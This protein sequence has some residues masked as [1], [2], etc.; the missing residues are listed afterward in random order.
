MKPKFSSSKS[1]PPEKEEYPQGEVVGDNHNSPGIKKIKQTESINNRPY[2]KTFRKKLRNNST[3]AEAKLWTLLQKSQLEGRKFRRQHSVG[4]YI[5]DFYCPS[6]KLAIEL[7]GE[8][9][10]NE[11]AQLR[12][13]ERTL[14]LNN[15]GINVIRFENKL[16]FENT[17]WVLGEVKRGF[18]HPETPP[19]KGGEP[20]V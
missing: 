14:F 8:V 6:E 4:N 7:D 5:V 20:L 1:S 11:Q 18:N 9:H 2:L 19:S 16:V 3:P 17:E 13:T 10:Y 12:D 15:Y